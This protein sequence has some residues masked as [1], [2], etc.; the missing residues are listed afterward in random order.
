EK[1]KFGLTTY[2][3]LKAIE[4]LKEAGY[5]PSIKLLHCHLGSQVANIYEIEV[6]MQEFASLFSEYYRLGAPLEMAD[7][8]GGLGIDYEGTRSRNDCSVNYSFREYADVIVKTMAK[9]CDE[10]QI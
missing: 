1:S 5:L 3:I 6:A 2:Q 10:K 7:V 9:I 4:H 8:G